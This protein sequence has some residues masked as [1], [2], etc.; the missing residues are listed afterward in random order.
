[1]GAK[2]QRALLVLIG[3]G[4]AGPSPVEAQFWDKLSNPKIQ[5]TIKHPPG[6]GMQVK[7]IAFGP[8]KGRESDLLIDAGQSISHLFSMTDVVHSSTV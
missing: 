5:V 3:V 8:S 6:L 4:L 2:K 7:R 1:M